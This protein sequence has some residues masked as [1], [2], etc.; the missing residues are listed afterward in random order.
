[1]PPALQRI[2]ITGANGHLGLRLIQR[3][4]GAGDGVTTVRALVRSER[5]AAT[6]R[7]LPEA[8]VPEIHLVD[9]A[10]AA[11]IAD[12]AEGCDGIVHLVGILKQ[13]A[14]NRYADAHETASFAV[15]RAAAR[16]G[17]R[18]VVYLS[19]LGADPDSSN[20]C[21]ASKGRA[22]RILLD[23]ETLTTVIRLP[24][25]L[26]EGD[27]ATLALLAKA[28]ASFLPLVRGGATLEQ[29]V[30]A[31]DV[32][33]AMMR[34]LEDEDREDLVLDLAGPESLSHH[35]LVLRA[36]SL[37]G[38]RPRV[39][40]IPRAL[41]RSVAAIAERT[42]ADPPLTPA[43]LGVLE[44]DD[45]IDPRPAC[46]RLGIELTPLDDTLRRVLRAPG[47]AA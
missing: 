5:A 9:Y 6:I 24:M 14:V 2:L 27:Y 39:V 1:M 26:G 10:D 42:L 15:A 31:E 43:M 13:T 4:A 36:A 45:Q 20:D 44:H 12:A 29:P 18:R 47:A 41:A 46:R 11:G 30:D 38:K 8:I 33:L 34:A 21:L 23:H 35:A 7:A 32:V 16:A 37:F 28:R 40:R 17:A 22:E 19:I 25:V 3:L